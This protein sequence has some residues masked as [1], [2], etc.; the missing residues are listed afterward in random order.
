MMPS[1]ALVMRAPLM[2]AGIV[3]LRVGFATHTP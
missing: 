3:M 2:R 1:T